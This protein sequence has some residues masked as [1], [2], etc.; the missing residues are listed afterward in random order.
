MLRFHQLYPLLNGKRFKFMM[1]MK[2]SLQIETLDTDLNIDLSSQQY[3]A[4][5]SGSPTSA[6]ELV[7]AQEQFYSRKVSLKRRMQCPPCDVPRKFA[8]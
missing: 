3:R 1:P 2:L 7:R 4:G 6:F 8:W 5:V